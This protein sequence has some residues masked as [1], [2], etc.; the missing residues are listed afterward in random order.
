MAPGKSAFV[1]NIGTRKAE[2]KKINIDGSDDPF[3]R[4]K[5]PQLLVQVV[6]KGKMIKTMLL[7]ND[8]VGKGLHIM[9]EYIPAYMGYEIGSQFKYEKNKPERERA[10]ISGEY[11][12]LELSKVMEKLIKEVIICQTCG[13]P[14]L[15]LAVEKKQIWMN[16]A[17]CSNHQQFIKANSKFIKYIGNHPPTK[18]HG[19]HASASKGKQQ[20]E[21]ER[22][23]EDQDRA[24]VDKGKEASKEEGESSKGEA[25]VDIEFAEEDLARTE[26]EVKRLAE[27]GVEW[28]SDVSAE[29]LEQRRAELVPESIKKL[30]VA[31]EAPAV[32]VTAAMVLQK[33]A[34]DGE[35]DAKL[36]IEL[37]RLRAS[38]TISDVD[39]VGALYGRLYSASPKEMLTHKKLLKQLLVNKNTQKEFLYALEEDLGKDAKT[40]KASVKTI[41][42]L[43]DHDLVE[44]DAILEWHKSPARSKNVRTATGPLVQW[45]EEAEEESD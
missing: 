30:V 41:K 19:A 27:K 23:S 45:L 1:V 31:E 34:E 43:Y 40:A 44:E 7:N 20:Q 18:I 24:S 12:S 14:E 16:C 26:E 2:A 29:A 39:A 11:T 9:P 33:L 6:G 17:S 32:V 5:V 10:S 8:E 37:E 28:K 42:M 3:Y 15:Q 13:L 21:Q 22:A 38:R 35:P 36:S 25:T 4:Y